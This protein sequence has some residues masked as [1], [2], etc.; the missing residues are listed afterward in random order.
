MPQLLKR[1]ADYLI[2]EGTIPQTSKRQSCYQFLV[3]DE[4]Q[5]HEGYFE[6]NLVILNSG[7]MT[8]TTPELK[9]LSK[10]PQHFS[11]RTFDPFQIYRETKPTNRADL[12]WNRVAN[13]GLP[14]GH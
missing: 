5:Q 2:W 3:E 14:I 10:L 11:G 12:Q 8:R 4:N 1:I 13:L 6:T 7:H 9:S